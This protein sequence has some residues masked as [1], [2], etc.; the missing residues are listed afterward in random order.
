MNFR[1][2]L[3]QG[4][5]LLNKPFRKANLAGHVQHSQVCYVE[6]KCALVRRQAWRLRTMPRL[7]M[8][9]WDSAVDGRFPILRE[10]CF[11]LTEV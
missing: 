2:E 3:G 9:F 11:I 6:A 7:E 4:V 5:N 8:Q 10:G 1:G